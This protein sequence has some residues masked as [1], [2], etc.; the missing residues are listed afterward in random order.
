MDMSMCA[1]PSPHISNCHSAEGGLKDQC[2]S[3]R[4]LSNYQLEQDLS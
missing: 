3:L 1:Q 2:Y 4:S